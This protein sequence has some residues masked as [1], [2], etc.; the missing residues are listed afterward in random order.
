MIYYKKKLN[1]NLQ[2]KKQKYRTIK[3]YCIQNKNVIKISTVIVIQP[4][5]QFTNYLQILFNR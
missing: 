2:Y 1:L 4:Y 5:M 3:R